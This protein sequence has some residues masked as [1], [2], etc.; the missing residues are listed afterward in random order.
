MTDYPAA[1]RIFLNIYIFALGAAVG[2]FLN[3]CIARLPEDESL[4]RPA[5]RCPKC[6]NPIKWYDNI[7][8]ISFLV[9]R[10]KCRNCGA[11]ISIQYPAVE[12]LTAILFVLILHGFSNI[13][14]MG[15]YMIFTCAMVVVA[16]IDL[17][18]YIIPNEISLPGI[19]I[20][21]LLSLAPAWWT[22][23]QLVA[24]SFLDSLIGCLVGGG[25]LYIIGRLSLL[26]LKK[27][28]MGGGDVKL[29]GMVGAFLGWK[30]ALLT[31]IMGAFGGSIVGVGLIAAGL[32]KRGK[33]IPFGPFLA[34]GAWLSM[35]WG[36][37]LLW[38]Y[39]NY[40]GLLGDAIMGPPGM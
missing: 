28:G 17:K 9:L 5:S 30:M 31:I 2:S 27:E 13:A 20:G 23:G 10:A 35:M 25:V 16:F 32:H 7:P 21:L 11:P 36:D 40:A 19:P 34:L 12:L 3:V 14:A 6:E 4:I 18:H 38:A 24:G 39:L 1:L 8:V 22:D 26:I 33:H 29:L 37:R 15:I